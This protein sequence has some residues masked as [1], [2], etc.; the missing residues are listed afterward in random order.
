M[1]RLCEGPDG[2]VGAIGERNAAGLVHRVAPG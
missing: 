1:I 2:Q